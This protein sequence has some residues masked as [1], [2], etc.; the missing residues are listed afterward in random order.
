[1][2]ERQAYTR[3]ILISIIL[4]LITAVVGIGS[5]RL[6][7][8]SKRKLD[9][10]DN[11]EKCVNQ[12]KEDITVL[13]ERQAIINIYTDNKLKEITDKLEEI[14]RQQ[15]DFNMKLYKLLNEKLEK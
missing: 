12:N 15:N 2:S 10:I 3:Q 8:S 14:Q 5:T 1:M 7:D 11:I 4:I 13:Y 6:N 9:K